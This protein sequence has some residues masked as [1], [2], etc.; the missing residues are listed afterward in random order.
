MDI[1]NTSKI[2]DLKYIYHPTKEINDPLFTNRFEDLLDCDA[3]FIS[4][5]N[6][7]HYEYLTK[8][9]DFNGYIFCEKPLVT[10]PDEL[11]NLKKH[12]KLKPEKIFFNFNYRFSSFAEILNDKKI[13]EGLG[14]INHIQII[15]THGLAFKKEYDGSWRSNGKNNMHNIL[16]T[17][18]IHYLD[19][20]NYYFGKI[21]T[22]FYHPKLISNVGS[23]YDSSH[24]FL[25]YENETTVS[26]FNSYASP[27]FN[28]ISIIGTNGVLTIK[29]NEITLS[30]PRDTFDSK[31]FFTSPPIKFSKYFNFAEEY[32]KSLQTS[33]N[34]FLDH[35]SQKTPIDKNQFE[36]SIYTTEIIF[37]IEN[38]LIPN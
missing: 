4:S 38:S 23:A 37:E 17:T 1:I 18:S 6:S 11:N 14:K 21:K 29:N 3:V 34:F 5:P 24:L 19:L 9:S 7:T 31:G 2:S 36:S 22:K 10:T 27:L 30:S 25:C 12:I 33:V 13:L 16:E 26:I 8:L 20:L 28:E 32:T 15:N 35:V